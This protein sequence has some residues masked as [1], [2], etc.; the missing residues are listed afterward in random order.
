[1]ADTKRHNGVEKDFNSEITDLKKKV[2]KYEK[3]LG[4]LQGKFET[5]SSTASKVDFEREKTAIKVQRNILK[6][7]AITEGSH[8]RALL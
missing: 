6:Q 1:M 3:D 7:E 8:K 4:E 5:L 2:R